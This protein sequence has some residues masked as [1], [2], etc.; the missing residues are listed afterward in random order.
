MTDT[1]QPTLRQHYKMAA[2][3]LF[4]QLPQSFDPMGPEKIATWAG[5]VA[6]AMLTED[7]KA[8]TKEPSDV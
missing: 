4:R 1:E 8:R 7:V 2:L 3:G 5:E 6:D